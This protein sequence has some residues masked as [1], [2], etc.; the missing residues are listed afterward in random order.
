MRAVVFMTYIHSWNS[1]QTKTIEKSNGFG[2]KKKDS[3]V[4]YV[5]GTK[6]VS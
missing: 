6:K 2:K 5:H 3:P 1:P 4:V